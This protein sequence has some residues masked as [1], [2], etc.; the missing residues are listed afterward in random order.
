[1][2]IVKFNEI[3]NE[4]IQ[5]FRRK[6][7][8]PCIGSGFSYQCLA[9]NGNVPSGKTYKEHMIKQLFDENVIPE[10]EREAFTK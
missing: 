3:K 7:L 5:N 4:I 10:N 6:S 1:M 8:I 2:K 9:Q